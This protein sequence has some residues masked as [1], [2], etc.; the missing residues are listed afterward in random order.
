LKSGINTQNK[1]EK[2]SLNKNNLNLLMKKSILSGIDPLLVKK[3]TQKIK[4]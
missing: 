1:E 3:S 2:I 4:Q